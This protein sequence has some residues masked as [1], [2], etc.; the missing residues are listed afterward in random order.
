M[1]TRAAN[2][3]IAGRNP[4]SAITAAALLVAAWSTCPALGQD[5]GEVTVDVE[6]CL[7]LESAEEQQACFGAQVNQV[8]Q[9]R[10]SAEAEVSTRDSEA[11]RDRETRDQASRAA[12]QPLARAAEEADS[13]D[14]EYSGTIVEMRE[15]M[16][17]AYIIRL[18]NG[19]IWEQT[20]PKRY[21]LRPGLEVRIYPTRWGTRYRLT[22]L[23]SGGHIQVRRVQ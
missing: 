1:I 7:E 14:V 11:D 22:G 8:L 10:S 13:Y 3:G 5:R 4:V 19:Q 18:D 21:P 12:E 6:R 2:E 9:E 16:P 23:D 17:S 20:E 15:Y